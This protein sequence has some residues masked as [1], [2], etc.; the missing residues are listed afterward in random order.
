M[1]R[2]SL[3]GARVIPQTYEWLDGTDQALVTRLLTDDRW[4]AEQK[5][6]GMRCLVRIVADEHGSDVTFHSHGGRPLVQA[7]AAQHFARLR[8]VF[9]T[10]TAGR[11]EFV[12]DGE[13]MTDTGTLWLFD[14]PFVADGERVIVGE[15]SPWV[16]RRLMLKTLVDSIHSAGPES[17]LP[18]ERHRVRMVPVAKGAEAK[19]DL[20]ETV[21]ATASEG[22]V[23]KDSEAT[24]DWS[25]NRV[26]TVLK[27]KVKRTV[28]CVVTARN[29]GEGENVRGEM[30]PTQNAHLAVHGGSGR[31]V[32]IGSTTMIGK[33]DA[34]VGD[35]VEVEYLSWKE[36]GNLVQPNLLRIRED[37]KPF[38]CLVTQL[39]PSNKEIL[40]VLS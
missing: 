40:E 17:H 21:I 2:Q 8:E 37:K 33:P 11:A 39:V 16:H 29:V 3:G 22:M 24:Y 19:T 18:L 5:L 31:L 12:L 1:T 38:E 13:L 23:F 14:L 4:V 20:L 25:G 9:S 30:K 27:L 15:S 28:D 26:R 36:G 35:V 7:A 32:H 6:D 10:T 34:Q